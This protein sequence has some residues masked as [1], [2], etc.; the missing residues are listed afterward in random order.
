[1]VSVT[2]RHTIKQVHEANPATS[3]DWLFL[4]FSGTQGPRRVWNL[5]QDLQ[6]GPED[7]FSTSSQTLQ[8]IVADM[9]VVFRENLNKDKNPPSMM[10]VDHFNSILILPVLTSSA[11]PTHVTRIPSGRETGSFL[12]LTLTDTNL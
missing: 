3:A 11:R 7:L 5:N 8:K 1:M 12:A 2:G 9:L 10:H 6:V 4:P